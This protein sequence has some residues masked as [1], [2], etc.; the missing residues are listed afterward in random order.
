MGRLNKV[1]QGQSWRIRFAPFGYLLLPHASFSPPPPSALSFSVYLPPSFISVSLQAASLITSST[2]LLLS[3][4]LFSC[5]PPSVTS[6]FLDTLGSVQLC[7]WVSSDADLISQSSTC[8]LLRSP[9]LLQVR[10]PD[11]GITPVPGP[12]EVSQAGWD[13]SEEEEQGGEK[14][15]E[16]VWEEQLRGY[17]PPPGCPGTLQ[18]HPLPGWRRIIQEAHLRD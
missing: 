10:P 8:Q 6:L 12:P 16:K 7:L 17:F 5:P 14:S 18:R 9:H 15:E 13:E 11:R 4:T 3:F 1:R 2:P